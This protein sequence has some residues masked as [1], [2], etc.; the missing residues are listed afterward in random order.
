MHIAEGYLPVLHAVAWTAVSAPL[1]ADGLV[2]LNRRIG[3]DRSQRY[4]LAAAA[5]FA[6]ALSALKLPSVAGSSSH[7]TGVAL[8]AILFGPRTMSVLGAL[9]LLF[10][11]LL[12]AHG[13]LTTL[14]ANAFSMAIAGPWMS[15]L[16]YRLLSRFGDAPAAFVAA[17]GGD[18]FTYVT[19]ALQLA[20]AFPSTDGGVA[21]SAGRFLAIFGVTQIPLA[22]L[23]GALTVFVLRS[24][25]A[26][27]KE[28]TV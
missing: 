21:A 6:F 8:G 26:K 25:N 22:L 12:L 15:W 10:Q 23:E 24:L 17:F 19:T 7:P 27:R 2:Q 13:G 1:I 4:L 14:G 28:A 3:Q 5:A 16:L 9:V 20:L 18:L 11:A